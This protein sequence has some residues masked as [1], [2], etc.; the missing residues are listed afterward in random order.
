[1]EIGFEDLLH[2]YKCFNPEVGQTVTPSNAWGEEILAICKQKGSSNP[3]ADKREKVR[4]I[5]R[6]LARL[7]EALCFQHPT[8]QPHQHPTAEIWHPPACPVR[9]VNREVM[10]VFRGYPK[11]RLG[12]LLEPGQPPHTVEVQLHRLACWMARGEPSSATPLACHGCGEPECVR[13]LCLAWGNAS[14]NQQD[15]YSKPARRPRR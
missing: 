5:G 7:L 3:R 14:T 10:N 15:A 4:G 6:V 13:L 1:M 11:A 12:V 8:G 2:V 9:C